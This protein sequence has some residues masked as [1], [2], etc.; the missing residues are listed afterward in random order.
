[1]IELIKSLPLILT[2]LLELKKVIDGF[3]LWNERRQALGELKNAFG[4]LRETGDTSE[5]ERFVNG[6]RDKAKK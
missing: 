6:L 1:M 2:F 5:L 4:K 3:Y